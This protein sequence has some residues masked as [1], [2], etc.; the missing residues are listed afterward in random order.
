MDW[1]EVNTVKTNCIVASRI[2]NQT[3]NGPWTAVTSA[4]WYHPG[5]TDQSTHQSKLQFSCESL[6]VTRQLNEMLVK[7][8]LQGR[9]HSEGLNLDTFLTFNMDTPPYLPVFILGCKLRTK[10]QGW[11]LF[12]RS[13]GQFSGL[14]HETL[15]MSSPVSF[16]GLH[17]VLSPLFILDRESFSECSLNTKKV[18]KNIHRP[19]MWASKVRHFSPAKLGP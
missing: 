19:K 9:H 13:G 2:T 15:C 17:P 11:I 6:A 8:K 14:W 7:I 5:K 4:W 16:P 3:L 12:L 1:I 10:Q 18:T